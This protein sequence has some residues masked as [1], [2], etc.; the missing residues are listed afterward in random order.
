MYSHMEA[1]SNPD[2]ID[3][4]PSKTYMH[5]GDPE[6]DITFYLETNNNAGLI[7]LRPHFTGLEDQNYSNT[8][9][10]VVGTRT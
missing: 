7:A 1:N 4:T 9:V 2:S 5:Q 8:Y 10:V 3:F 6:W